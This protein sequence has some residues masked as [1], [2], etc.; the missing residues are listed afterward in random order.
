MGDPEAP[1]LTVVVGYWKFLALEGGPGGQDRT[2][3]S[4]PGSPEMY[5][6]GVLHAG[7]KVR[8]TLNPRYQVD[9]VGTSKMFS[10]SVEALPTYDLVG[11]VEGVVWDDR[12]PYKIKSI[13]FSSIEK[14]AKV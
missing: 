1:K 6:E 2:I 8:I 10:K 13:W 14:V 3:A 7:D 12:V 5:H 11:V 4:G 9:P